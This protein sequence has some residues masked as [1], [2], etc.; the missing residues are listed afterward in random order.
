MSLA[1]GLAVLLSFITVWLMAGGDRRRLGFFA[2]LAAMHLAA[3]GAFWLISLSGPADA[4]AYYRR[5]E[6]SG[7]FGIGTQFI[8]FLTH[9]LRALTGASFLDCFLF[10]Q[11]PGLIG[12]LLLYKTAAALTEEQFGTRVLLLSLALFLPGLQFWTAAIGK[13]ALAVC[14]Y[15]LI[16]YG[17]AR[18]RFDWLL[19]GAGVLLY[20]LV[21]PHVG[22]VVLLAMGIAF[23]PI[24]G[25]S[26]PVA[27]LIG[28]GS[29]LMVVLLL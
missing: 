5:A 7:A 1:G 6:I 26:K 3:S 4:V 28:A 23:L 2:L 11:I 16:S 8:L 27:K 14:A 29:A 12:I 19:L 10:F 18:Q 25:A 22:F 15:G 21:R 13:D 24:F 20:F 9:N 17:L